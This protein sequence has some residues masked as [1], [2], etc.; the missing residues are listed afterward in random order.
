MPSSRKPAV[1][2]GHAH[3]DVVITLEIDLKNA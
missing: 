1:G 2:I 3:A